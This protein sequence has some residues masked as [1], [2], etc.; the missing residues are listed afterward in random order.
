MRIKRFNEKTNENYSKEF[1][2]EWLVINK[3]IEQIIEKDSSGKY[4][5][6]EL[7]LLSKKELEDILDSLS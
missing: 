5:R 6:D 1:D 2:D 3:L 4:E 7:I